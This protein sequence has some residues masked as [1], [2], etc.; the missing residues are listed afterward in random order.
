MYMKNFTIH[1]WMIK[2]CKL[3]G[4]NLIV[5]SIIYQ[6]FNEANSSDSYL[7]GVD[8]VEISNSSGLSTA[9]TYRSLRYLLDKD[10]IKFG[11]NYY[12]SISD[13]I[14]AS[15]VAQEINLKEMIRIAKVN[16]W[17]R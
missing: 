15:I 1:D 2:K 7:D 5:F 4:S 17:K 16:L 13:K 8:A 3:S 14:L 6:A 9:T 12:Y 10:L 11:L